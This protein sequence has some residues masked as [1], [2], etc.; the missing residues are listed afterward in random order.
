M[1]SLFDLID[2]SD[3]RNVAKWACSISGDVLHLFE[4][5]FP[6]DKRPRKAI[7]ACRQWIQGKIP[8]IEVRRYAFESHAAAREAKNFPTAMYVAR[9]CGQAA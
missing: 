2:H 5:V 1:H 3:H 9:A 4:K 7:E 8:M 6:D